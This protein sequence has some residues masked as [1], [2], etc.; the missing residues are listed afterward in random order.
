MGDGAGKAIGG[1]AILGNKSGKDNHRILLLDEPRKT[2]HIDRCCAAGVN[3]LPRNMAGLAIDEADVVITSWWGS[4]IMDKFLRE[5]P[6][7]PCRVVLWTHKN[8][9]YDPPLPDALVRSCDELLVTSPLTFENPAWSDGTLVYG[10]GDF[11]PEKIRPKTDYSLNRDSFVIGYVGMPSYKR[12]PLNALDYMSTTIALI[13][14]AVF[15][16]VGEYSDEFKSSIILAGLEDKVRLLGWTNDALSLLRTFDV[17]GY[18]LRSD[19]SAT[20]ENSVLEAMAAGLPVVMSRKPVGKYLVKDGTGF[21]VDSPGEYAQ[22]LLR[23]YESEDLRRSLGQA[24][25]KHILTSCNV[26]ENL[27]RFHEACL[28]VVAKQKYVHK[29]GGF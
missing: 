28:K 16:L 6:N 21:L 15:V 22:N 2:N 26:S 7:I 24:A 8:G 18:L 29:F 27:N 13:P 17:F 20:T 3:V 5:F 10:F 1:L 12:F 23:I 19:S 14:D 11:A 4:P 9:F 25:R